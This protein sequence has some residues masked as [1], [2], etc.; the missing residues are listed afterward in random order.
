MPDPGTRPPVHFPGLLT[1]HIGPRVADTL[2]QLGKPVEVIAEGEETVRSVSLSADGRRVAI[3]STEYDRKLERKVGRIRVW[4][5]STTDT[6]TLAAEQMNAHDDCGPAPEPLVPGLSGQDEGALLKRRCGVTSVSF[7]PDGSKIVS[8][9]MGSASVDALTALRYAGPDDDNCLKWA[10]A[11]ENM[12]SDIFA[13]PENAVCDN[14]LL[15]MECEGKKSYHLRKCCP[16]LCAHTVTTLK[17]DDECLT[18]ALGSEK[19]SQCSEGN[20]DTQCKED[21]KMRACC[22][23]TC[24][25]CAAESLA[26]RDAGEKSCQEWES[27]V[28]ST[29]STRHG[30]TAAQQQEL[31]DNCPICCSKN[32]DQGALT[33]KVWDAGPRVPPRTLP[34]TVLTAALRRR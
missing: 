7:S 19:Y 18:H 11:G 2:Q 33:I 5:V 26:F 25:V 22:P 15:R 8:R 9:N 13:S 23:K 3:G 16:T 28:C 31:L 24:A 21:P 1:P 6:P 32:M 10:L 29:A 17:D 14:D 27:E 34:T 20:P 30:Y 4:D 12:F